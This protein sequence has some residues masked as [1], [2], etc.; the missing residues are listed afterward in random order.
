M[1]DV[2]KYIGVSRTT[3]SNAYNRPDQLSPALRERV[4]AAAGELGY[5]GPDPVARSLRRGRAGSLGLVFDHPLRFI[6]SDP[7]AVLFLSGVAAGCEEHGTGLALVPQLPEGAAEVVRSALVDGYVMFCTPED[8][9]RLKAV[10]AR[11]L[12]YV[13]VD[14]SPH[15]PGPHVNIDDR[16]GARAVAQHLADLGH[17]RYGIVLP[18]EKWRTDIPYGGPEATAA[19]AEEVSRPDLVTDYRRWRCFIR[20]E[21]LIGWRE[22]LAPAGVDWSSVPV[23]SAPGS[24][25]ETGYLAGAQLLDRADRPTAIICL[26]DVLALGVMRAAAERGVRVPQDLSVVGYDDISDART[27]ALTTVWQ[28]H[29]AKGE[30]AV[31]LLGDGGDN[32]VLPTRLVVRASSGP[33]PTH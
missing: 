31:R 30:E 3:V 32:V 10:I 14:Y 8:D 20:Y 19:R 9:E 11:G 1:A 15:V 2:A 22:A 5:G 16:G 33:V 24:D 29:A 21:R 17:R 23:A 6:F 7:A 25:A 18:Y 28:P 4:L 12:P 13:L 26:S 27:A